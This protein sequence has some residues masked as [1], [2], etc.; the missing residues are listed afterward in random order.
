MKK[1]ILLI[2]AI[3]LSV[4]S[5]GFLTAHYKTYPYQQIQKIKNTLSGKSAL[6]FSPY[7]YHK[8]SFFEQF[9]TDAE[10]IMIGDSITDGADWHIMFPEKKI[11]NFGI[12]GDTTVGILNR[13]DIVCKLKP[14]KVFIMIGI[15]DFSGINNNVNEVFSNYSKIIEELQLCNIEPF[16][17][18]TILGGNRVSNLNNKINLLNQNLKELA[19]DKNL[20]F[21]NLNEKLSPDGVLDSKYS[22]DDVHLNGEGYREW[23]NII[24]QYM[25]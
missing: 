16:I 20:K 11:L 24:K 1:R 8:V 22:L 10:T 9:K 18:S 7:Y 14:K 13:L 17:Q 2:T 5:F 25:K 21:I 19:K 12:G 6:P 15:N 23:Q 3:L 4:W